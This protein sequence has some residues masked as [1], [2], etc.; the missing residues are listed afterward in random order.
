MRSFSGDLWWNGCL[1][2][3]LF[4]V[5]FGAGCGED[6]DQRASSKPVEHAGGGDPSEAESDHGHGESDE[7]D[8]TAAPTAEGEG[9]RWALEAR[10]TTVGVPGTLRLELTT[11]APWHVNEEYPLAVH[12]QGV[13]SLRFGKENLERGDAEEAGEEAIRFQIP[14]TA[15]TAGEHRITANVDFAVCTDQAC[16]PEERELALVVETVSAEEGS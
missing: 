8:D 12:L 1:S 9:Y 13:E 16:V 6:R 5:L 7:P 11:Q 10:K 2:A 14:F 4:G 3:I 15:T